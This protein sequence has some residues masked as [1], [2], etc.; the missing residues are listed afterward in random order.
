MSKEQHRAMLICEM[1]IACGGC[2]FLKEILGRYICSAS[3]QASLL[4][5]TD[6]QYLIVDD[7]VHEGKRHKNCPLLPVQDVKDNQLRAELT[8]KDLLT[9]RY[10]SPCQFCVQDDNPDAGC[11]RYSGSGAWCEK[12]AAWNG[13]I[14]EDL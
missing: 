3:G 4:N 6:A 7:E 2:H 10:G 11:V 5:C 9:K 14:F 12:H 1:P 8:I 13:K